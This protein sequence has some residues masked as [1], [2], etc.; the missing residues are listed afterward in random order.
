MVAFG[1][2]F[3]GDEDV[4]HAPNEGVDIDRLI[5]AIAIGTAALYEL[6]R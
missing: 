4:I 5:L 3:E 2:C 1:P 6:A